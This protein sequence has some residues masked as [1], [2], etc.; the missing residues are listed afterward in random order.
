MQHRIVLFV[1][2]ISMLSLIYCQGPVPPSPS[3]FLY[4]DT[5]ANLNCYFG[6]ES[7][8]VGLEGAKN[9]GSKTGRA[10]SNSILGVYQAG[11][12]SLKAAADDGGIQSIGAID[13]SN[14]SVLWSVYMKNCL[15]VS[16]D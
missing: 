12:M 7:G 13:F 10:C 9:I 4:H 6:N 1:T 2:V 16:G 11:D 14:M 15:I 5:T 8:C 3:A